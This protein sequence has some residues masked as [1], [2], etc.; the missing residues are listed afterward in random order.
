MACGLTR[1]RRPLARA[2]RSAEAFY[3]FHHANAFEQPD[4]SVCVDIATYADIGVLKTFKLKNLRS[5][6]RPYEKPTL[7]R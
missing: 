3:A 1:G 7:K 5:G 2:L 4:G 6:T